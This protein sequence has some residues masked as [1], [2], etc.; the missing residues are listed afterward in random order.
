MNLRVD[1]RKLNGVREK[2]RG[3]DETSDLGERR[4]VQLCSGTLNSHA[5]IV[6]RLFVPLPRRAGASLRASCTRL[7]NRSAS[8]C[9]KAR[10]GENRS[11]VVV[12]RAKFVISA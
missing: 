9:P 12:W 5:R 1:G 3:D 11:N 8:W 7:S 4:G 10:I 6:R 2:E